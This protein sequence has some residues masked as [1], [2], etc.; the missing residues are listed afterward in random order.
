VP[1]VGVGAAGVCVS[2]GGLRVA[3]WNGVAGAGAVLSSM[4]AWPEARCC[5]TCVLEPLLAQAADA[6][7]GRRAG[8]SSKGTI[9]AA[10]G[11]VPVPS[12]DGGVVHAGTHPARHLEV[13][14]VLVLADV[15]RGGEELQGRAHST[16]QWGESDG[17]SQSYVQQQQQQQAPTGQEGWYTMLHVCHWAR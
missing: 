14:V 7:D 13:D 1:P 6:W 8:I 5:M 9:D 2:A 10:S 4:C 16:Q 17:A 3:T 12:P 15:G 11:P